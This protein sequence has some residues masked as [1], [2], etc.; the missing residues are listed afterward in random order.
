MLVPTP[1]SER[2]RTSKI[3]PEKLAVSPRKEK[4][5][6]IS[7]ERLGDP[8][9]SELDAVSFLFAGCIKATPAL[10]RSR[11]HKYTINYKSMWTMFQNAS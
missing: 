10:N 5:K 1:L 4:K 3:D 6:N 11:I 8:C 9:S 7:F 2:L